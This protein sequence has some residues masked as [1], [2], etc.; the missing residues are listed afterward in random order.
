M[1]L[2]SAAHARAYTLI[3]IE[4]RLEIIPDSDRKVGS[5]FDESYIKSNTKFSPVDF[6]QW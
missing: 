6:E 3:P 2:G 1:V 4:R 5:I